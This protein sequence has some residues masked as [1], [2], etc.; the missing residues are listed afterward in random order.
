MQSWLFFFSE[1]KRQVQLAPTLLYT[2]SVD[3]SVILHTQTPTPTC[4]RDPVVT[5]HLTTADGGG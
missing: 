4:I 1:V 5:C 3:Y 2:L